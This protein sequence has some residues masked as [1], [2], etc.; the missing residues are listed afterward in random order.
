MA[1]K[2]DKN[3]IIEESMKDGYG[4]SKMFCDPC[5]KDCPTVS[6]NDKADPERPLSLQTTGVMP[7]ICPSISGR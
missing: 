5:C 6:F 3:K 2:L 1:N 4:G 7:C